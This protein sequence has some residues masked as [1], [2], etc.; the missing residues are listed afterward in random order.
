MRFDQSIRKVYKLRQRGY[1]TNDRELKEII[2]EIIQAK[3]RCIKGH[4]TEE[5]WDNWIKHRL[6]KDYL[7][8]MSKY[9][10]KEK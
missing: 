2:N 7:K 6:D 10:K 3:E 9:P 5:Q 1:I 8:Q 4:I